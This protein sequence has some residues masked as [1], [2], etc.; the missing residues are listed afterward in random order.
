MTN[1]TSAAYSTFVQSIRTLV[2]EEMEEFLRQSEPQSPEPP[3]LHNRIG[4]VRLAVEVTGLA[5][6]T[7]Y[8]LA[9]Q[10]KIP[11]YKPFGKLVFHQADLRA[12]M[13]SNRRGTHP[14]RVGNAHWHVERP[15]SR[16]GGDQ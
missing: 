3:I 2:R 11:H 1:S 4:G 7:I 10:G 9:H 13:L 6:Q 8:N 5:K 14:E 16:R 15:K 12:W